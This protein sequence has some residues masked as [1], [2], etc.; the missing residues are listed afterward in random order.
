MNK[1][2]SFSVIGIA[3]ALLLLLAALP[4]Q[5]QNTTLN[6]VE[7]EV[8]T[9]TVQARIGP[10]QT[11]TKWQLSWDTL[12]N[13]TGGGA[14]YKGGGITDVWTT[15]WGDYAWG[16]SRTVLSFD[17]LSGNPSGTFNFRVDATT[18]TRSG[19]VT[20]CI[21]TDYAYIDHSF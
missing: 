11:V 21:E 12:P 15:V 18:C 17:P 9:W 8:N 1:R 19:N 4:L 20:T 13:Q 7:F 5:A 16:P 3:L 14:Q 10:S 2:I 6:N